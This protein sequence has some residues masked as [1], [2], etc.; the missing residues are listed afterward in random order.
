MIKPKFDIYG[1]NSLPVA[2]IHYFIL[3]KK[4]PTDDIVLVKSSDRK[5]ILEAYRNY[6]ADAKDFT[7]YIEEGIKKLSS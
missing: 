6:F 3:E 5:S 2:G 4:Y 1:F 7:G